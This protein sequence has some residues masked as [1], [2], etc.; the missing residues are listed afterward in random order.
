MFSA[1]INLEKMLCERET[2][3]VHKFEDDVLLQVTV[4]FYFAIYVSIYSVNI[5]FGTKFIMALCDVFRKI[6]RTGQFYFEKCQP[7]TCNL[8]K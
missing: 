6:A 5:K 3:I 4:K 7:V 1:A 8:F 2:K